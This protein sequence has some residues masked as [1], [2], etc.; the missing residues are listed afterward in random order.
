[1][2][3]YETLIGCFYDH[4]ASFKK[5]PGSIA[6]SSPE[7]NFRLTP[8]AGFFGTYIFF[9]ILDFENF[10][11]KN[12]WCTFCKGCRTSTRPIQTFKFGLNAA[13]RMP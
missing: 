5:N 11:K 2:K 8:R 9:K 6:C 12:F 3:S 7:I 10:R 4:S 1:M 13:N